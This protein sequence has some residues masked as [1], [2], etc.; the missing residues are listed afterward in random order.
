MGSI[1]ETSEWNALIEHGSKAVDL[2]AEFGADSTRAGRFTLAASDLVADLSKHLV[3]EETIRLLIAVAHRAGL[4]ERIEAMFAGD[5][6]NVTENRPV[7]HTA[8]RAAPG[9]VFSIDDADVVGGVHAVLD[10]MGQFS[11]RV[12][13]GTWQGV[14]EQG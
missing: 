12:R 2:R 4:S 8:L 6:I 13:S 10:Q 7:L 14:V 1:A 3:T 9:D 5:R 11:D